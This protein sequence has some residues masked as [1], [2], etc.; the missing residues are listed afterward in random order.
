LAELGLRKITVE[1]KSSRRRQITLRWQENLAQNKKKTHRARTEKDGEFLTRW[2][3]CSFARPT[4][5][6]N[7]GSDLTKQGGTYKK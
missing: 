4:K 7:N 3:N 5:Q 2:E 1:E 6:G